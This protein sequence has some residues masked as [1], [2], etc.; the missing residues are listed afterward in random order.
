[1]PRAL[2]ACVIEPLRDQIPGIDRPDVRTVIHA[3]VKWDWLTPPRPF[4]VWQYSDGLWRT[5]KWFG[6]TSANTDI[7][8]DSAWGYWPDAKKRQGELNRAIRQVE[9]DKARHE[10][11]INLAERQAHFEKPAIEQEIAKRKESPCSS[12]NAT[13]S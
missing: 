9:R 7:E 6:T 8:V 4:V 11:E 3:L 5:E 12:A 2:D 13:A 1:M 10:R